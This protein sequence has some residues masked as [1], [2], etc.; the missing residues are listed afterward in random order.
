MDSMETKKQ[1]KTA[2][3]K[4]TLSGFLD[5]QRITGPT[6]IYYLKHHDDGGEYT[7]SDWSSKTGVSSNN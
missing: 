3:Q 4:F 2:E 6:K 5:I 7:L 1:P